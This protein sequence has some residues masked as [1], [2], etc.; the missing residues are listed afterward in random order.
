MAGFP[1]LPPTKSLL[2]SLLAS[3]RS[4]VVQ[5]LLCFCR[6]ANFLRCPPHP[7]TPSPLL[8]PFN[9]SRCVVLSFLL[10]LAPN[11]SNLF[12][13]FLPASLFLR[14]PSLQRSSFLPLRSPSNFLLVSF[15][16]VLV[17]SSLFQCG[18][19]WVQSTL[20]STPSSFFRPPFVRSNTCFLNSCSRLC[21]HPFSFKLP[22]P[23]H[24]C[25]PLSS[26]LILP[27]A[28]LLPPT[29]LLPP[30]SLRSLPSLQR[31]PSPPSNLLS[32]SWPPGVPPSFPFLCSLLWVFLVPRLCSVPLLAS[33][34]ALALLHF[35]LPSF[36]PS[37]LS[38]CPRIVSF[39]L[40]LASSRS[41]PH[42]SALGSLAPSLLPRSPP[43]STLRRT[44]LHSILSKENPSAL[45]AP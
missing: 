24:S 37:L 38:F 34:L 10:S 5:Q 7:W 4:I 40:L 32:S 25:L 8:N 9:S 20:G 28:P 43:A 31:Y 3:S 39:T 30:P 21:S 2:L 14:G 35:F 42:G 23:A 45:D 29:R 1:H 26:L 19:L 41:T 36:I 17:L 22:Y 6:L 33:L 18:L 13:V 44:A 11:R 12:Q 16:L 15:S 27:G